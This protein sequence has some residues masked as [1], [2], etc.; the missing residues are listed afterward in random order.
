MGF[1]A[2]VALAH[3]AHAVRLAAKKE[4]SRRCTQMNAD[5]R[6]ARMLDRGWRCR[7][8]ESGRAAARHTGY[9][10]TSEPAPGLRPGGASAAETFLLCCTPHRRALKALRLVHGARRG[11][12]AAARIRTAGQAMLRP[13]SFRL[14]KVASRGRRAARSADL[15]LRVRTQ[16]AA[17][18]AAGHVWLRPAQWRM[19]A[20]GPRS[21]GATAAAPWKWRPGSARVRR[22]SGA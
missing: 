20:A 16:A 22:S 15:W 4:L 19:P 21:A 3:A 14:D 9:L 13:R 5:G 17:A 8:G 10:R 7:S 1:G 12:V 2:L 6:E 18:Q 11:G